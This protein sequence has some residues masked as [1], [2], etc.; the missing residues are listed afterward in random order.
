M[1]GAINIL[2]LSC[3]CISFKSVCVVLSSD[4][5][6]AQHQKNKYVSALTVLRETTFSFFQTLLLSE[7]EGS[8]GRLADMEPW[9]Q[10]YKT[11]Q[12]QWHCALP[13][14]LLQSDTAA[15]TFGF[16]FKNWIVASKW[17]RSQ[18]A[19]HSDVEEAKKTHLNSIFYNSYS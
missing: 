13:Q 1:T 10:V 2:A 7:D 3:A 14:Q 9:V 5:K 17:K 11:S 16:I 19:T 8:Y 18:W 12:T 15:F 6:N 4:Q